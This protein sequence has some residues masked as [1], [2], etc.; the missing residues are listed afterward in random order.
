MMEG[1]D[2]PI[3]QLQDGPH[4]ITTIVPCS[5]VAVEKSN[6]LRK[7]LSV[8]LLYTLGRKYHMPQ[9]SCIKPHHDSTVQLYLG[10]V[11]GV[12]VHSTGLAHLYYSLE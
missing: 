8:R 5:S 11:L 6:T 1:G 12:S 9:A 3:N 4:T 10:K 2:G 7:P